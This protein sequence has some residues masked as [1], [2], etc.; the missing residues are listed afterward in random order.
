MKAA[1]EVSAALLA[2]KNVGFYSEFP[3]EGKLPEGLVLCDEYGKPVR[4]AQDDI[5]KDEE[6]SG[7]CGDLCR[8]TGSIMADEAKTDCGVAVTVHTSCRPFPSTTQVRSQ[9]SD[10]GHGMPQG[11]GRRGNCRSCTESFG[12]I[13]EYIKKHLNR[14]PALI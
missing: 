9:M 2:G 12:Q 11:Q 13:P 7:G 4:H 5:L 10:T 3:V 8:N 14:S 1:K 6:S